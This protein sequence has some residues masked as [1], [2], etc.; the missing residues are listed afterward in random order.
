VNAG[1]VNRA[2]RAVEL[3]E[4]GVSE[5]EVL[6]QALAE[7]EVQRIAA[8]GGETSAYGSVQYQVLD[9]V[10]K[11]GY[12]EKWSQ[13]QFMARQVCKAV[14]ELGE[15]AGVF[16]FTGGNWTFLRWVETA[17]REARVAFDIDDLPKEA[18]DVQVEG[19]LETELADVLI[20][21][22]CLAEVAEVDAMGAA[23]KKALADVERG[24][25]TQ[26]GGM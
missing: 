14:E 5:A 4:A 26:A 12:A 20:P 25:R 18:W 24:V 3:G 19:D 2:L 22:L 10:M 9:A 21:L 6:R 16:T 1:L 8:A 17:A 15:L 11:R 13:M 7:L 23:R